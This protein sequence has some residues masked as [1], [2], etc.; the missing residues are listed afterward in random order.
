MDFCPPCRLFIGRHRRAVRILVWVV[1]VSL[2]LTLLG[3]FSHPVVG[4]GFCR[5]YY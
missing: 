4:S 2:V 3:M 1:V 5:V